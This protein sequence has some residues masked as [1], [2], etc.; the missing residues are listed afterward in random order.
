MFLY[1]NKTY[2]VRIFGSQSKANY[3]IA[4]GHKLINKKLGIRGLPQSLLIGKRRKVIKYGLSP[5]E[6]LNQI[7]KL[8]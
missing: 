1:T 5:E 6:Y 4:L 3:T 8:N 2:T 7:D